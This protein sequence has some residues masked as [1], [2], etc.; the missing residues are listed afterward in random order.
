MSG[1]ARVNVK[2][3]A[4]G[5]AT[6]RALA[7]RHRLPRKGG[8]EEARERQGRERRPNLVVQALLLPIRAHRP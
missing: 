5:R 3:A 4:A 8:S 7:L 6:V 1:A 2:R